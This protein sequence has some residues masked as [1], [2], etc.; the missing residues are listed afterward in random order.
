MRGITP[1]VTGPAHLNIGKSV[2][3]QLAN[4]LKL[5]LDAVKMYNRFV[6]LSRDEADNASAELFS[7]LLK[8]EEKHA[9][10]LEAQAH[11]IEEIGYE[12]YLS[13]QMGED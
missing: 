5:E 2:K 8:D 3:E 12:R 10:W 9:D 7:T 11:L 1:S 4:D 13:R 6:Q